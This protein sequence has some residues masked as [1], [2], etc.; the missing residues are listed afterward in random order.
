MEKDILKTMY[1]GL[2]F[3]K[4][5][6]R[7]IC[8]EAS[9]HQERHSASD[10]RTQFPAPV[11]KT[12][13]ADLTCCEFMVKADTAFR[14]LFPMEFCSELYYVHIFNEKC[15]LLPWHIEIHGFLW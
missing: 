8:H 3:L 9:T 14:C 5:L 2:P 15:I 13:W 12:F 6:S 10:F 4:F 11:S 1:I 7:L